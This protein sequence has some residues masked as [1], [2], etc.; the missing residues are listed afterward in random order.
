[1]LPTGINRPMARPLPAPATTQ[2]PS[3]LPVGIGAPQ[4][5]VQPAVGLPSASPRMGI[6]TG[7]IGTPWAQRFAR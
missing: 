2:T 6:N 1:M 3:G 5:H 4:P 7:E